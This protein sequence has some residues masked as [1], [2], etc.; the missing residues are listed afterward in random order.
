MTYGKAYVNRLFGFWW[1]YDLT[2]GLAVEF[3][4]RGRSARFYGL[5]IGS[6]C[7]GITVVLN[8]ATR[9]GGAS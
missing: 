2:A 1:N 9:S 3:E 7:L 8:P 6:V 4:L 5:T